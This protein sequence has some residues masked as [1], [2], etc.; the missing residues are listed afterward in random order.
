MRGSHHPHISREGSKFSFLVFTGKGGAGHSSTASRAW[1]SI[2]TQP[3]AAK[4][5]TYLKD[6]ETGSSRDIELATGL[7]QPSEL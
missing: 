3:N 1:A 2:R 5:I 6:V 7:S 4:L